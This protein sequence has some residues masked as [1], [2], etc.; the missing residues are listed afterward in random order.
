MDD[1]DL[2]GTHPPARSLTNKVT[3]PLTREDRSDVLSFDQRREMDRIERLYAGVAPEP[4]PLETAWRHRDW[5]L[6]RGRVQAGMIAAGIPAARRDRFNA[7]GAGCVVE[8]HRDT[9]QMRVRGFFCGDRFCL[10]CAKARALR[11]KKNLEAWLMKQPGAMLT[12][13]LK[14]R[15]DESC[16]QM[17][18]R[19]ITCFAKLRRQREWKKI[20]GGAWS[21]EIKRGRRRR[22]WHVHIHAVVNVAFVMERR[23]RHAWK[24]VT[25][26]SDQVTFRVIDDTDRAA[27]YVAKYV[28]K[29]WAREVLKNPADLSEC[30]RS[31]CGRRLLAT[32]GKHRPVGI[33]DERPDPARW[34]TLGRLV[35]V[36]RLASEGDPWACG[37]LSAVGRSTQVDDGPTFHDR[38]ALSDMLERDDGS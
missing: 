31:L 16:A 28:A 6:D 1:A 18:D 17:I 9:G 26:D 4:S 7:C 30:L 10:A 38:K 19:L 35:E 29:G 20:T 14:G 11:V 32:F 5:L 27:W 34:K 15:P 36:I 33:E 3:G 24:R 21:V 2:F 37:I 13:T 12:L 8:A 23:I 22:W 25:T